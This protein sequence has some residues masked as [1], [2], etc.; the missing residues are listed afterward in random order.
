MNDNPN[1]TD[2]A[3]IALDHTRPSSIFAAARGWFVILVVEIGH[4]EHQLTTPR[5]NLSWSVDR[6]SQTDNACL[7]LGVTMVWGSEKVES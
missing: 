3:A 6:Q 1:T 5:H 4:T 2:T 7:M